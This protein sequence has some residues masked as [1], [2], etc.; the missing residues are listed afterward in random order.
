[1]SRCPG[2]RR[3]RVEYQGLRVLDDELDRD[4]K[5]RG[6]ERECVRAHREVNRF[7]GDGDGDGGGWGMM[8]DG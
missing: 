6:P 7:D 4:E 3:R 5:R 8:D 2:T 1:V